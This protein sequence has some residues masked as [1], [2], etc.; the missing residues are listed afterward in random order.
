MKV[1]IGPYL[2]WWGPYQ[3][4]DLLFGNPDKWPEKETWRHRWSHRLGHWLAEK[5]PVATWCQW[6]YDRRERQVY[7]H[8]DRYDVWNMDDTLR[9][10]IGPMFVKLK[11]TKHGSG[12]VEDSDVPDHLKSTAAPPRENAW[13]SDANLHAR[14]DWLLDEMIWAFTTDH[15]EARHAFYDHSGVD[16]SQT[17][18]A[19]IH[20]IQIDRDALDAYEVRVTNAYR[21]FGKYYQT[22]W[23]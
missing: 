18:E 4:A 14:Y 21:L 3:I 16:K 11:A 20:S 1:K 15:E 10:I 17:L 13:D 8:I 2:N 19:Q 6:I 12:F 7:V 22:F 9:L 23:D 5:T